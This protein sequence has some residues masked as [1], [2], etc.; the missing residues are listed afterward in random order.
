[1]QLGRHEEAV[2]A[3]RRASELNP[4]DVKARSALGVALFNVDRLSE[5]IREFGAILQD[6][7]RDA[8]AHYFMGA[9]WFKL[10][11][12]EEA[13]EEY[14]RAS[15]VDPASPVGRFSQGAAF[16]RAGDYSSALQEFLAAARFRPSSEADLGVYA[17]MQLLASIGIEHSRNTPRISSISTCSSSR[18]S[19][20]CWMR[21]IGTRDTI[22]AGLPPLRRIWPGLWTFPQSR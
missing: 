9:A 3:F 6:H 12:L 10:G 13:I 5:A 22:R 15:S 14:Q 4:R 19:P 7:P 11:N 8:E 17:T 18:L 1:M 21:A 16:S 2:D 20:A